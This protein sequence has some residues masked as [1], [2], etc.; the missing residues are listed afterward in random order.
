[1]NRTTVG[2]NVRNGP[3]CLGAVNVYDRKK[4]GIS[5]CNGRPVLVEGL[6]ATS[7]NRKSGTLF[8]PLLLAVVV[9]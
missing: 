9:H 8:Q 1:M 3:G 6:V 7:I 4:G 2:Q 5:H